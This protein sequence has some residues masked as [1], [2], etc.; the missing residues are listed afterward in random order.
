M[1]NLSLVF[2]DLYN[3]VSKF[4]GTYGS[5]GPSGTDL[6]DAKQ[7]VNDAYR[8]F[9]DANTDWSFLKPVTQLTTIANTWVYQLPNDYI[10]LIR[11]FQHDSDS[12][13]PE[14]EERSIDDILS[15]KACND[16]SSYPEYFALR[17]SEYTKETGQIWEVLFFPTP[18]SSYTLHYQYKMYPEKL[19][20]DNDLPVGAF[21]YSDC[22]RQ[23]CLAEA[24]SNIEETSGTQEGKA[25]VSLAAAI[26][27]DKKRA[28][29]TLGYNG[30]GYGLSSWEIARGSFRINDVSFST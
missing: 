29:H 17:P 14:L 11:T 18:D 7:I 24:E 21:E 2:S 23:L 25:A 1:A 19:E 12:G 13:Y 27:N 20:D 10:R 4:L 30:D 26:M 5:S 22:I 8:R 16:Y 9:L 3:R 6:T 28:P 15:M